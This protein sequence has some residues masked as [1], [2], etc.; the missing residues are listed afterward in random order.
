MYTDTIATPGFAAQFHRL[1][2][3]GASKLYCE[4]NDIRGRLGNINTAIVAMEAELV[5]H[6]SS[7]SSDEKPAF[8]IRR[9]D[10][11]ESSLSDGGFSRNPDGW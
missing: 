1:V 9:E 10:Y 5:E 7:R 3:L 4:A 11:G 2:S 8:S 6:Y